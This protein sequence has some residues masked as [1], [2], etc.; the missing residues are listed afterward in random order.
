MKS[1]LRA[2]VRVLRT[3]S[4]ICRSIIIVHHQ[5]PQ[6]TRGRVCCDKSNTSRTVVKI[7]DLSSERI[8]NHTFRKVSLI[9]LKG[10]KDIKDRQGW[11]NQKEISRKINDEL[12]RYTTTSHITLI[13]TVYLRASQHSYHTAVNPF[14]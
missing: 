10:L 4:D 9:R 14:V 11:L 3:V 8:N 6:T 1:F 7:E 5:E 2:C 12:S 13:T